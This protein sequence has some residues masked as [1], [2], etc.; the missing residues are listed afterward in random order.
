MQAD[1]SCRV[2][3]CT[4][5][6]A[7]LIGHWDPANAD[8]EIM[9]PTDW[10]REGQY[11]EVVDAVTK[12][13]KG[14]DVRVYKVARSSTKVEYFVV[15]VYGEGKDGRLYGVKALGVESSLDLLSGEEEKKHW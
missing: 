1:G 4:E 11:A 14:N 3:A 10:D 15:T 8:V 5:E 9:D 12:A 7:K 2:A 13:S 6:F